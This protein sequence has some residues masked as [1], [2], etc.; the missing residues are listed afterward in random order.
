[1]MQSSNNYQY[2]LIRSKNVHENATK[3]DEDRPSS[4]KSI[5]KP[6]FFEKISDYQQRVTPFRGLSHTTCSAGGRLLRSDGGGVFLSLLS[7]L[8]FLPK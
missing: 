5:A 4:T 7:M 2:R 6:K 8:S 3:I 1:M